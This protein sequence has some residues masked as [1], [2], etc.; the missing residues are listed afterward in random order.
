M[1]PPPTPRNPARVPEINPD[2]II[3]HRDIEA[4]PEAGNYIIGF[5]RINWIRF[6]NPVNPTASFA[7]ILSV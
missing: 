1:K 6:V 5:R 2:I 3:T 4:I 7:S